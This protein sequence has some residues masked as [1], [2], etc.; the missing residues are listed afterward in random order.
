MQ[1]AFQLGT[2]RESPYMVPWGMYKYIYSVVISKHILDNYIEYLYYN[3]S[4]IRTIN[5][6][7][8]FFY[9][10]YGTDLK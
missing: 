4:I 5:Q 8:L 9:R 6:I 1:A 3:I 7:K 10:V 2:W